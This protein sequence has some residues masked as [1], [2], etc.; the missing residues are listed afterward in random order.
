MKRCGEGC[1]QPVGNTKLKFSF[2][3][4]TF[5][6]HYPLCMYLQN[7]VLATLACSLRVY[8]VKLDRDIN[9]CVL[10]CIRKE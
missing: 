1:W 5:L 9:L 6:F 8:S 4:N 7:S 10:V 2:L 3:F